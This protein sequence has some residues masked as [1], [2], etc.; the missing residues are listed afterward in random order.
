MRTRRSAARGA[1]TSQSSK[2]EQRLLSS[3]STYGAYH[4][5]FYNR[6]VHCI[7]VPAIWWCAAWFAVTSA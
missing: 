6:V 4:F 5:E 2:R 3:L 1:S 7:F